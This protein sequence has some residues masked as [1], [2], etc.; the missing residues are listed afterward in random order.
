MDQTDKVVYPPW[1]PIFLCSPSLSL[2]NDT[3]ADARDRSVDVVCCC[4]CL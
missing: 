1:T 4:G 3:Y 2:E